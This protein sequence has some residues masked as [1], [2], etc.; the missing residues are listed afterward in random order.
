MVSPSW[1]QR[2]EL[3]T[4]NSGEDMHKA[5]AACNFCVAMTLDSKK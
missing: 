2:A 3:E 5:D 4:D 1:K